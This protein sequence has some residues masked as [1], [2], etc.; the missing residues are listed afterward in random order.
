MWQQGEE[1]AILIGLNLE[2]YWN[3]TPNEYKKY[4]KAYERR[5]KEEFQVTDYLNWL[6]NR[7]AI[8]AFNDPKKYPQKPF[9]KEEKREMTGDEMERIARRN[10]IILNTRYNDT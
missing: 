8:F 1:D 9:S 3:L 6:S 4:I 10:N 5:K 2:E 7:Y